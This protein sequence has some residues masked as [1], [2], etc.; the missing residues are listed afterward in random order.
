MKTLDIQS[1]F[2]G[3]LK[4]A[5]WNYKP[6]PQNLQG[7]TRFNPARRMLPKPHPTLKLSRAGRTSRRRR[8]AIDAKLYS[9]DFT[10]EATV[11]ASAAAPGWV[12]NAPTVGQLLENLRPTKKHVLARAPEPQPLVRPSGRSN[13]A[14]RG[15]QWRADENDRH[16]INDRRRSQNRALEL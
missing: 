2:E 14:H 10:H 4:T 6:K 9:H 16:S 15:E 7:G 5:L 11:P 1:T 8:M 13:L 3:A 12:R